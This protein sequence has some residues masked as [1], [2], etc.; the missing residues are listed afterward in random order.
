MKIDFPVGIVGGGPC[1][2]MTALLLARAGVSS[3]VLERKPGTSTH[4]K[5]MGLSRRTAEILRQN[6]LL[7]PD[8]EKHFEVDPWWPG[9]ARPEPVHRVVPAKPTPPVDD[10]LAMQPCALRE[11]DDSRCHWPLGR[12]KERA[13]MFCGGVTETGRRYCA[14]HRLR[15]RR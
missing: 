2:M 11:L 1:G 5:A 6:G 8:V 14:H 9:G 15:A 12:L 4:P 3:A 13:T 10:S 7:P